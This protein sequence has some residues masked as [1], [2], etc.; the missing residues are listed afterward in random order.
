M[1]AG[2]IKRIPQTGRGSS[3]RG[4]VLSA[5]AAA[6]K[7]A[8]PKALV[9]EKLR[10]D[11]NELTIDLLRLDLTAFDRIFVIGGGKASAAM[12]IEIEN[13]LGKR[14]TRGVV[15]IPDYLKPRPTSQRILFHES[16]HPVPSRKGVLGVQK[17]LDLTLNPSSRDLVI[18][19]IS[20]GGSSL[21]PMPYVGITLDDKK[22]VTQ[23]L[24]K[25]GADI[26]EVNTVRKH[27]SA[28]KGGRLAERLQPATVLSLIIS[29]VVGDRLDSIAS[30]PTA[31]DET[32]F[33]DAKEILTR[34]SLW[35]KVSE[36]VRSL[37]DKGIGDRSIETPKPGSKVFRRVHNILIGSNTQSC[38]AAAAALDNS[39]YRT[40]VLSS[41]VQGEAREIGKL[42]AGIIRSIAENGLPHVPPV[43]IV[44]GGE[45]TVTVRGKGL[46]GRNQELALSTAIGIDGLQNVVMASMGTDGVDGPTKAAGA[47]VDG[48]TMRRAKESG[49]DP[50]EHLANN[51]SYNFFKKMHDLIIT[52][53]T[54]TNVNDIMILTVGKRSSRPH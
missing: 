17:M 10:L 5:L 42:Y 8:D 9:R 27:L 28:I 44:L 47:I 53:P 1:E 19:L 39:G 41:R 32:T 43:A 40:L 50:K 20:G 25:S 21:L 4:Q 29:D 34:Y 7:S 13:V 35:N 16:T 15:N 6:I 48:M 49:I 38:V 46:G 33:A 30:G 52:G 12:A 11:G 51:D 14:I 26:K 23:F 22:D 24:L 45:T 54:G 18:C 2:K 3:G 37:L 31:P 36:R